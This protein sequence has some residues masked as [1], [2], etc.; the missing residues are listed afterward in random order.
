MK[1][2]LAIVDRPVDVVLGTHKGKTQLKSI[3][4]SMTDGEYEVRVN[5][6]SK[7]IKAVIEPQGGQI[8]N[9]MKSGYVVFDAPEEC[10][11]AVGQLPHV[12][13][14]RDNRTHRAPRGLMP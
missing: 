3:K 6:T 14:V 10:L 9:V 12:K 5:E 7:A 2:Y 13:E 1:S 11:E 8:K 4:S